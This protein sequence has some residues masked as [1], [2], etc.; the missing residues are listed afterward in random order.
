MFNNVVNE[1]KVNVILG[2]VNAF[3]KT[4]TVLILYIQ[5]IN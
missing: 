4:Y 5:K 2:M 1:K 3:N